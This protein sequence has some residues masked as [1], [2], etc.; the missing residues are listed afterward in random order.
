MKFLVFFSFFLLVLFIF[1]QP[2]L[3]TN[4]RIDVNLSKQVL[5]AYEEEK[6]VYSFLI[7]SGKWAPTPTGRFYP[8]WKTPSITMK[9]GD[10]SKDTYYNLPNVPWN[11]F[12]YQGYA[13]HGAYW[14]NNFGRPM[15][16][17]CINERVADARKIYE[18]TDYS[19][20]I[21]IHY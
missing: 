14:H 6:L 20:P 21:D 1:P 7:S 4:K 2:V 8:Y 13:L 16:H 12:F 10:K 9:G 11:I 15:S 19:T 17:G 3:A 5:N 18:F